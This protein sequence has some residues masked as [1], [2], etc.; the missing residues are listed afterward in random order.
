MRSERFADPGRNMAL[1]RFL[2]CYLFVVNLTQFVL[3]LLLYIKFLNLLIIWFINLLFVSS[4]APSPSVPRL[5]ARPLLARVA[6]AV[7]FG[8]NDHPAGAPN[9]TLTRCLKTPVFSGSAQSKV[10]QAT[11]IC[12]ICS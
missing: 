11:A 10:V 4:V 7:F 9:T 1:L 3:Y 6:R 12:M 5:P 8:P 2:I